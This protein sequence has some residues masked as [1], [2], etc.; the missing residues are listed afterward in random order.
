MATTTQLRDSLSAGIKKVAPNV[1]AAQLSS[2]LSDGNLSQTL[3]NM[4]ASARKQANALLSQGTSLLSSSLSGIASSFPDAAT[5]LFTK[6]NLDTGSLTDI[7]SDV[8]K[9]PKET[10]TKIKSLASDA[11]AALAQPVSFISKP[12]TDTIK[13]TDTMTQGAGLQNLL[14]DMTSLDISNIS[15]ATGI[16]ISNSSDLSS[17]ITNVT[18]ELASNIRDIP[19]TLKEMSSSVLEPIVSTSKD[20]VGNLVSGINNSLNSGLSSVSSVVSSVIDG[21]QNLTSSVIELLPESIQSYVSTNTSD[22]LT[23]TANKLLGDDLSSLNNILNLLPGISGVDDLFDKL[24]GLGGSS[25][26]SSITDSSGGDLTALFGD[27]DQN[28]IQQIYEVAKTIC[29]GINDY[30]TYNYRFNKDLYDILLE[31]ASELGLTDLIDQLKKCAGGEAELFD[32]RSIKVLQAAAHTAAA[33]GDVYTYSAVQRNI[34]TENLVDM[35]PDII[36]LT[37][38]MATD[39]EKLSTY[40]DLMS[41]LGYSSAADL[42]TEEVSGVSALNGGLVSVMAA[43]DTAVIDQA[44][45]SETRSLV[46]SAMLAYAA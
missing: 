19:G 18:N 29:P 46:E 16:D 27:N 37:A 10:N 32:S 15:K 28:V 43:T 36:R 3:A 5:Q 8:L 12:V 38:N 25:S 31:L 13:G 34:G 21:T 30:D 39:E 6:V 20:F 1:D 17:I 24:L 23:S 4:T 2:L 22:F 33:N 45:G 26:Y 9:G 7:A 41:T 44:I 40:N 42:V 35:E 11:A 14:S